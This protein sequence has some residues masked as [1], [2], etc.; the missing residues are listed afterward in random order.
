MKKLLALAVALIFLGPSTALIGVGVL[1]NPA[2]TAACLPG[3]LIVGQIPD[4]LT[5]TTRAGATV[6]LN[7]T[8]LTHA[9]TIITVGAPICAVGITPVPSGAA[10]MKPGTLRS[11]E[12]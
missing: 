8:Q 5:A 9:A 6:T 1:M 10:L 4:S 7:K 12:S 11:P 2:A 3:S